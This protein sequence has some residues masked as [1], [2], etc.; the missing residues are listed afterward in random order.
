MEN[1]IKDMKLFWKNENYRGLTI[2]FLIPFICEIIIF[3]FLFPEPLPFYKTYSI[4]TARTGISLIMLLLT[5]KG[6][7]IATALT[8]LLG[9]YSLEQA[10]LYL[11]VFAG[12]FLKG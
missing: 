6:S 8:I 2:F 3:S 10:F 7:K 5:F 9:L 11:L 12:S 1:I 4:F